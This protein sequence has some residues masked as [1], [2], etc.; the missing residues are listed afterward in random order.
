MKRKQAT[1]KLVLLAIFIAIAVVLQVFAEPLKVGIYSIAFAL[2]PITIASIL[3]GPLCGMIVGGCWGLYIFFTPDAQVFMNYNV[4]YTLVATMGRGL[5]VGLIPGLV[6]KGLKRFSNVGAMITA[7]I[8]TPLSNSIIF[9]ICECLMFIPLLRGDRTNGETIVAILFGSFGLSMVIE[10]SISIVLSPAVARICQIGDKQLNL[11][12]FSEMHK[13]QEAKEDDL[14]ELDKFFE[15]EGIADL[16]NDNPKKY[17]L[18]ET[19]VQSQT[20]DEK[21]SNVETSSE[22]ENKKENE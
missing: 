2:V 1:L 16:V 4:F 20:L 21:S 11:G 3:L 17:D 14:T 9:R 19:E 6:F 10:L 7:S 13:E 8:I 22:L 18:D 12:I 5:L 15:K